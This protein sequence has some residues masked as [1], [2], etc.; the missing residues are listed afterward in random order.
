M[1]KIIFLIAVLMINIVAAQESELV[2]VVKLNYDNGNINI[3]E[4]ILKIGYAPDRKIQPREGYRLEILDI[5]NKKV[6]KITFESPLKLYAE[7]SDAGTKQI[8]GTLEILDSTDFALILP[9]FDE[10][11]EIRIY[12]QNGELVATKIIAAEPLLSPGQG[13]S[14]ILVLVFLII[15]VL[16]L[17]KRKHNRE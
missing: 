16:F 14:W 9:H 10:E 7:T 6:Y 3:L 2:R 15:I 4:D 5:N 11:K 17:W 13:I 8:I 12:N 1:K